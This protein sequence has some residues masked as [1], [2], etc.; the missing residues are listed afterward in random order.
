MEGRVGLLFLILLGAAWAC[1][2]RGLANYELNRK[3]ESDVCAL[4]EEYATEALDYLNDKENQR[5]IIDALHN[6]CYQ[7]LSFKQQCI[8]LVDDYASHFFSEIAS[9][10]PGELCKQVHL[11]QSANVSSQVKGNSCGSC[12]DS[13]AALLV[14]LND[15]DTKL[16]IIE[17]LLTACNSMEKMEKKCKRMVFEYGPMILVKAEKFLKTT[18]ICTVLHACP[19]SIAVSSEASSM[20][21]VPLISDS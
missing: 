19:A 5:K 12:K 3:S 11:C 6:T 18:D 15:P 1:D 16:E 21:E 2:A 17:A 9:V 14:K 13:V 7:L 20:E 8:E 10:L 4:C